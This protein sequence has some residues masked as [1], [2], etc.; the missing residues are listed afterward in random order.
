MSMKP[1]VK[2]FRRGI[3]SNSSKGMSKCYGRHKF[4]STYLVNLVFIV[5]WNKY[6]REITVSKT[7]QIF[8]F[9]K[10]LLFKMAILSIQLIALYYLIKSSILR[11]ILVFCIRIDII[12][13]DFNTRILS[14][15]S[16]Q[17]G[18]NYR[19]SFESTAVF[20]NKF[21]KALSFRVIF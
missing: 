7:L 19:W 14:G 4:V 17:S 13:I 10:I 3:S 12:S 5:V 1:H 2:F 16:E 21:N 15:N 11:Y 8:Y 6:I 18:I 9:M 20:I